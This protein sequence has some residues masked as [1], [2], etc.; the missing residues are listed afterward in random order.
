MATFILVHGTFARAAQ[1]PAL[2]DGLAETAREAGEGVRF[3]QLTWTGRNRASARQSAASAILNS[4]RD[5]RSTSENE[6][7]F[8][9]GHSHGGSAI[10]Y[11]LKEHP[12]VIET[13]SGCA[14]LSTP[15]VAIRPRTQARELVYRLIALCMYGAASL[16]M[17]VLLLAPLLRDRRLLESGS[18][19]DPRDIQIS[20][21][22]C[23]ALCA[24]MAWLIV[25]LFNRAGDPRTLAEQLNR[26]QTTDIPAGHYL[27]LRCSGD[28]A[29]AALSTAQFIAWLGMRV[30][31]IIRALI[32]GPQSGAPT[33]FLKYYVSLV[34]FIMFSTFW[35]FFCFL[36]SLVVG[37]FAWFASFTTL[38]LGFVLT[39]LVPFFVF[40]TQAVTSWAFGWTRLSTGFLAE[41]AIEPLPFGEHSL[42]HVD[43]SASSPGLEGIAHSWTYA[44][45]VAIRHIQDWVKAAL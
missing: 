28:E 7:I 38:A 18:P 43:W 3:E 17:L 31:K 2:Q 12:E 33:P 29:A 37:Q 15:F 30:F 4:V 16:W 6:K 22:W 32:S 26:Q 40:F 10:A 41:L 42:V 24:A 39:I 20:L 21:Y 1:W 5:I 25:F 19:Y 45:P 35:F 11:F 9:I 13:L 36:I 27:F 8:I 23:F 34:Y 44:H 14:F